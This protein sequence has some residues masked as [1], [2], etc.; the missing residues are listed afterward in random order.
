MDYS[1][2]VNQLRRTIDQEVSLVFIPLSADLQYLCGV[3]RDFPSFGAIHYPGDWI[4]GLWI[5][6]HNDPVLVLTRMRAEF[7]NPVVNDLS[8]RV[9]GDSEDPFVFI[10]S[11][12]SKFS[13]PG[14]PRIGLGR[15]AQAETILFLNKLF[16][17][18]FFTSVAEDIT[19]MRM[20]KDSDEIESMREAGRITESA[21][22]NVLGKLRHGMTE[23]DILSEVDFQLRMHGSIGPS[24]STAVYCSGPDHPLVLGDEKRSWQRKLRPPVSILFDLGAVYQG[25]CYDYGRTVMFGEPTAEARKVHELV[26]ESQAKGVMAMR[27]EEVTCGEVDS[28]ARQ[29][30]DRAGY[31]DKFR[32][33]LGHGIGLDVH[34]PP[35]LT[36]SDHTL[37]KTG[38]FFTVE[39]SILVDR[40]Y[41]AR[42]EDVVLVTEEG[43][44]KLT[45][46]YQNLI[47]ID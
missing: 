16:P 30:I 47:V 7:H 24:F 39:P 33:R 11:T 12:L 37:L 19:R 38:M 32:H 1:S 6:S 23:L 2:R 29:V 34:E 42:V 22:S 10:N 45:A 9:I 17:G 43:G 26:M 18:A 36:E 31:G 21:F 27:A 46:G 13:I 4:E 41:S 15:T 35:F 14:L 28:S 5:P 20:I 25:Y 8:V 3:E 44:L 40:S